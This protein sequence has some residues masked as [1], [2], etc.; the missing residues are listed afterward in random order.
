MITQN[1]LQLF[2]TVLRHMILGH[3]NRNRGAATI[4]AQFKN[5]HFLSAHIHAAVI[6]PLNTTLNRTNQVIRQGV[7]HRLICTGEEHDGQG[8]TR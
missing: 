8:S 7:A 6:T 1:V 5:L 4:I 3:R 2:K